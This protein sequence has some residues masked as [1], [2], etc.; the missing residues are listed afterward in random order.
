[1]NLLMMAPLLDSRGNL[2]YF[3]GAQVDVSGLVKDSTDLDAFQ[4]MLDRQEGREPEEEPKDEFQELSEMFNNSELETVRKHGGNMHREH[5]EERDDASIMHRPRVL[6]KDMTNIESDN[7]P[8]HV[9]IK[10][11]GRLA[12]VY[13]H[14]GTLFST[15]P[16]LT[17]VDHSTFLFAHIPP[18]VSSSSRHPSASRE[19]SNPAFST[20][21]AAPPA[22]ATLSP[23][24]SQTARAASPQKCAG[25][26]PPPQ[27]SI[28]TAPMRVDRVGYTALRSLV[29]P[30]QWVSGWSFS[31]TT[32]SP[33]PCGDSD[34]RRPSRMTSGDTTLHRP[35]LPVVQSA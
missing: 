33:A 3:I 24:P 27:T 7:K 5:L 20:A 34:K 4:S 14:V 19:S 22:S 12:G 11:E 10:P 15:A 2:R 18:F 28:P 21:S 17:N 9:S 1:M 6:I 35:D 25:S 30:A 16:Y 31:S 13:K 29:N 23:K 26:T 32:R 8:A